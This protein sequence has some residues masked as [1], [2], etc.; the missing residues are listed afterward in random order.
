MMPA[1]LRTPTD[2]CATSLQPVS[3]PS[4]RHRKGGGTVQERSSLLSAVLSFDEP[5]LQKGAAAVDDRVE[6]PICL[7]VRL[8][9]FP[10]VASLA[11]MARSR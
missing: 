9:E 8:L 1:F 7:E 3:L 6:C 10:N 11:I 5:P 4:P 2:E